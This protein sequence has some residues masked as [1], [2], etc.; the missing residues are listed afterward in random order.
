MVADPK[1]RSPGGVAIACACAPSGWAGSSVRAS[2]ARFEEIKI[3][4]PA[5][6]MNPGRTSR[7]ENGRHDALPVSA[8]LSDPATT[9]RSTGGPGTCRATPNRR[10][11]AGRDRRR[12]GPGYREAVMCNNNGHCRK[13]D[14]GTMCPGSRNARRGAPDARPRQH[15]AP[16]AVRQVRRGRAGLGSRARGARPLCQLQ[17]VP[18]RMPHRRG[19]GEDED[20]ALHHQQR[21]HG[22]ALRARLIAH[23]PR[24][25]P[26]AAR[27]PWL[28]NLR[29]RVPGAAKL[30][31]NMA[32]LFGAAASAGLA[33][34]HVPARRGPR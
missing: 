33:D 31:R 19:H 22:L 10:A 28:A 8:R 5:R 23:L 17:G 11:D 14:A 25:A 15:A 16:C 18:A 20:E 6:L 13:F 21:V 4:D 2:T 3:F 34:R 32:R 7:N 24:Y 26:H 29:N 30:S 27:V 1:A 12:S 9:R